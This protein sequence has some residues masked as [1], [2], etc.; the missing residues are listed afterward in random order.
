MQR[1]TA[2]YSQTPLPKKL[3]IREGSVVALVGAP[4]GFERTLGSLPADVA[5]RRKAGG[6][7]DLTLWFV[8]SRRELD[9]GIGRMAPKGEKGGLWIAWPKKSSPLAA[10]VGEGDVRAAGL[11]AGL[12]D[13]K[14]CAIDLDWSGLRF[15]RRR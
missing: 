2:G 15:S 3:G 1:A 9:R 8:R 14:V 5:L 13:F 4:P 11:A 7:A 6:R 12:V 10:D